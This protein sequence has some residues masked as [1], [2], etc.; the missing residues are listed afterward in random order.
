MAFFHDRRPHHTARNKDTSQ[1]GLKT[2]H[3]WTKINLSS[4]Q[5][6]YVGYFVTA[7]KSLTKVVFF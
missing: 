6:V 7:T 4:F 1:H 3:L 2:R 5:V